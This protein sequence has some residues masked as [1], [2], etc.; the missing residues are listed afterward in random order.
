MSAKRKKI[1]HRYTPEQ[2]QKREEWN[3]M[4]QDGPIIVSPNIVKMPKKYLD[5]LENGLTKKKE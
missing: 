4:N 5:A 1:K 2:I 3:L